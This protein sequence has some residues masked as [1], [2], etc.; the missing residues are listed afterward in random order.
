MLSFAQ[1]KIHQ[2]GDLNLQ[3]VIL[4]LVKGDTYPNKAW[5]IKRTQQ[6]DFGKEYFQMINYATSRED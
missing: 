1:F 3:N 4:V 2:V 5:S 6:P